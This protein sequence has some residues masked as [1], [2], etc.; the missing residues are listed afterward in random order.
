MKIRNGS[1]LKT[2]FLPGCRDNDI[3][4]CGVKEVYNCSV[5]SSQEVRMTSV[6]KKCRYP[7]EEAL[8]FEDSPPSYTP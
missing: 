6:V 2:V 3:L 5:K 1:L 4:D 7:M 8:K